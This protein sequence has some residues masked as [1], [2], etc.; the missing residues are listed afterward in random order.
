M[1][2]HQSLPNHDRN[3]LADPR[4]VFLALAS[5]VLRNRQLQ[6]VGPA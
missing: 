2:Q 1:T 6:A 4:A 5:A 3:Q